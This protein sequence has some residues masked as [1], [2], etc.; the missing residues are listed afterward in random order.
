MPRTKLVADAMLGSLA[1]KLRAFGF[2]TLY[3]RTGGDAEMLNVARR[4]G[5]IVVTA[6]RSL[7]SGAEKKGVG[8]LLVKGRTDGRRIASLLVEARR[9]NMVLQRGD[10]L[11]SV[12]DGMLVHLPKREAAGR[13]PKSVAERHRS[14][15]E[16]ADCGRVYWKGSHWKK[17]RR[18][19]SRFPR[20]R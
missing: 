6:D 15:Y 7:A 13:L 2:D 18:L 16:C 17:L 11:C 3:Y 5:R 8:A 1:R 19:E 4:Q 12:C 9:K 10:A 14:F 20:K